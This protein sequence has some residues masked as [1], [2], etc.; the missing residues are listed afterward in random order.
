M[1]AFDIFL[2][3]HPGGVRIMLEAQKPRLGD[4]IGLW[5]EVPYI[6]QIL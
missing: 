2:P 1:F 4:L 3:M 5:G 6:Q